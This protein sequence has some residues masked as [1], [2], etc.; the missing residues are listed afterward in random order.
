ML[1]QTTTHPLFL[2]SNPTILKAFPQKM[3]PTKM[4]P[5]KCSASDKKINKQGKE[6]ERRGNQRK[7]RV[8]VKTAVSLLTQKVKFQNFAFCVYLIHM[9]YGIRYHCPRAS[10]CTCKV[11]SLF[12]NQDVSSHHVYEDPVLPNC[13]M[14]SCLLVLFC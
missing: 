12:L 13:T 2:P 8:K 14:L 7:Q 6:S 3:F 1:T 11:T 9:D 5:C 10:T 4:K